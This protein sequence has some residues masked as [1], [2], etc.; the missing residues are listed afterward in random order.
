MRRKSRLAAPLVVTVATALP[1]CGASEEVSRNPPP[2]EH[3]NPPVQTPPP[4]P[5]PAQAFATPPS[6]DATA[7]AGK[8]A[9]ADLPQPS[10]GAQVSKRPD[11]TC[12]ESVDTKCP[13]NVPCNPPPPRQV[14]CP[15]AK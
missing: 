10:P 1:G 3:R 11:G 5:E 9:A 8:V 15:A 4:Q 14:A 6:P 13:P 12:W 2:L 7:T